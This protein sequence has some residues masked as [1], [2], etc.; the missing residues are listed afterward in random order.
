MSLL[1]RR[2]AKLE[3]VRGGGVERL[4]VIIT[5]M[6]PGPDG[7]VEAEPTGLSMMCTAGPCVPRLPGESVEDLYARAQRK[8]PE[9]L[10]WVARYDPDKLNPEPLS[11]HQ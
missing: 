1:E 6:E 4:I 9:V 7:P 11:I 2:I 10:V 8:H 3:Q 5:V